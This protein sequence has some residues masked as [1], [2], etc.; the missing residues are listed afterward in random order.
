[1]TI[2]G[3]PDDGSGIGRVTLISVNGVPT[4]T[5]F[6]AFSSKA[7]TSTAGFELV[8]KF[9][10]GG[11]SKGINPPAQDVVLSLGRYSATFPINSFHLT[12]TGSYVYEGTINGVPL[13]ARISPDTTVPNS[14]RLTLEGNTAVDL[15]YPAIELTIGNDMGIGAVKLDN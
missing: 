7:E 11:A 3:L 8:S 2:R 13:E 5:M 15:S 6:S 14:Y 12:S 4:V 10:L 9:T 1:M